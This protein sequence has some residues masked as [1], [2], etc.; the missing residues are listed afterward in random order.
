MERIMI[1]GCGGAGKST[2][3]RQLGEKLKLPVIHLDKLFWRPGWEHISREEFDTVLQQELEK[4]HWIIDGN[5]NRTLPHRLQ[6]CDTVFYLDFPTLTCLAGITKRTLTNLGKA[7]EDMGGN[8]VEHFDR[9][10][11]SLYRKVLTFNKQHRMH[12]YDLL[13]R[14]ENVDVFIFKSRRQ[15]RAFLKKL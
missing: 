11:I 14:A 8:C 12:Y 2:L 3:A 15:V 4:P 7:R 6:Y 1:I 10:K 13:N 5:F 9:Q